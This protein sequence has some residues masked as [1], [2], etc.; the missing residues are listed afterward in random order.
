MSHHGIIADYSKLILLFKEFGLKFA[1][2][3]NRYHK[4]PKQA[5]SPCT[6]FVIPPDIGLLP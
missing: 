3:L 1:R 4:V 2:A 6:E 5:T